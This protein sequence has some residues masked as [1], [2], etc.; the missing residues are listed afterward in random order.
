MSSP[1]STRPA[2]TVLVEADDLHYRI[3]LRQGA[4]GY[5]VV[6]LLHEGKV[7]SAAGKKQEA[8]AASASDFYSYEEAS[9][10]TDWV[11]NLLRQSPKP[12]VEITVL[13]S[14]ITAM[15]LEIPSLGGEDWNS[16]I[17]LEAQSLTGLYHAEASLAFS[18]IPAEEGLAKFWAVQTPIRILIALREAVAA[19]KKS[20]LVKVGHPGGIRLD[21][22]A[23]QLECWPDFCLFHPAGEER[24]D[25]RG[26]T[27]SDSFGNAHADSEIVVARSGAEFLEL[28]TASVPEPAPPLTR[29]NSQPLSSRSSAE[30]KPG[31]FPADDFVPHFEEDSAPPALFS[32][33]DVAVAKQWADRLAASMD[34]LSGRLGAMPLV[35]IPK[36]PPRQSVLVGATVAITALALLFA[37][38]HHFATQFMLKSLE[39]KL[40]EAKKPAERLAAAKTRIVDL[41]KE[42]TA[43]D[44]E[45]ES[46]AGEGDVDPFAHRQRLATLLGGVATGTSSDAVIVSLMPD[47]L[48][49]RLTG[50]ASTPT[51]AQNFASRIDEEMA[52]DGWRASLT[53][54]TAKLLQNDGGPWEFEILLSPTRP[55]TSLDDPSGSGGSATSTN[56][57]KDEGNFAAPSAE[58]GTPDGRV[59]TSA[60]F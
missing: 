44:Q 27:G 51:G 21:P 38:A 59:H 6:R 48:S 3:D 12:A 25:L 13:S 5:E 4:R 16:A 33:H 7:L 19:T 10:N 34:P 30:T 11:G 39:A 52:V 14:A 2:T 9:Y 58:N 46:I 20:R 18:R 32:L 22:K 36:P 31:E 15:V 1:F 35:D 17:E 8:D 29:S 49:T 50:I 55:V 28:T 56:P 37:A 41:K 23:A 60:T 40:V 57:K 54:R 42:I 53:R 26:W 45:L 24:L 43:L 47:S